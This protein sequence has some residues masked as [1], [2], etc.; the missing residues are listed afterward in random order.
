MPVRPN[1]VATSSH[2]SSTSC[3]RHASAR[4]GERRRRRH[5]HPGRTLHERLD[6]DGGELVGVLGDHARRHLEASGVVEPGSTP[7]GES[8]R[9]EDLGA[10]PAGAEREPTHRVAVVGAAE[11]EVRRASVD[12]PVHPVLE[13]DLQRLLDG[14]GAV[15]RE[16]EVRSV[17][18]HDARQGLGQLDRGAV[19]VAE[20]R[21]VRDPVEL[22]THRLV[23]LGH[24]VAERGDPE[25]RDGV[26][27]AAPVDVDELVALGRLDD[28]RRVL[29]V[30]GHLREAVPDDGGVALRPLLRRAHGRRC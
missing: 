5:L 27:V 7:D 22:V 10:E 15:R 26:E 16:Q 1:P 14:G 3:S 12:T 21:R 19:P 2:T 29:R 8:Q 17:D 28:D 13:R 18:R 30:A 24:A 23:E 9:V 6:D 20:H 11:R 25:R 4:R